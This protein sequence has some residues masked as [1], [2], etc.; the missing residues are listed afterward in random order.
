M[1]FNGHSQ[2]HSQYYVAI[3]VKIELLLY[4]RVT[5]SAKCLANWLAACT[6]QQ[7]LKQLIFSPSPSP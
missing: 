4:I 1:Q 7:Q 6:L 3:T 5:H 2:A